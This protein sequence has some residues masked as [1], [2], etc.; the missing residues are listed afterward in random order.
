MLKKLNIMIKQRKLLLL[1]EE[2]YED[3]EVWYP[4]IRLEEE[5]GI[6]VVTVAPEKRIYHGK[7][8]YPIE[9]DIT[10]KQI[11]PDDYDG[12]L[13]PGGFAPDWLRRIPKILQMIK[14]F[15]DEGK[16]VAFICH[17]GWVPISAK[18]LKGRKGTSFFAIR[19]DM[20]NAGMLW[21]DCSVVIDENLVSSRMPSD[22]GDYCKGILKVLSSQK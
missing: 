17:A 3:L 4:K 12:I 18:I 1:V 10:L 5:S 20:E 8:G 22:L 11:V 2:L 13:I 7:K 16:L 9:P 14:K 21:K 6:K 15:D 19:D